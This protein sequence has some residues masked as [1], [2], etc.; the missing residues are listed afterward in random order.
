M[1]LISAER[2]KAQAEDVLASRAAAEKAEA[3]RV[4]AERLEGLIASVAGHISN[5]AAKGDFSVTAGLP[6]NRI[7]IP[8][9]I[10]HLR[11][12]GYD[13]EIISERI[14]PFDF[15]KGF[16]QECLRVSWAVRETSEAAS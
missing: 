9:L 15:R 3:E 6:A 7:G 1:D 4:H 10:E 8:A 2:V 11:Q 14:S 16:S 5:A 13:V 12:A